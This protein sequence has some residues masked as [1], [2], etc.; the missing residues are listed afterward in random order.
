VVVAGSYEKYVPD[1]VPRK[2]IL[3]PREVMY[4]EDWPIGFGMGRLRHEFSSGNMNFHGVGA[5]AAD[6]RK[7]EGLVS[8]NDLVWLHGLRI[9]N[10]FKRW[11]WPNSILDIDDIPSEF[12][13]S[14]ASQATGL[15]ARLKAMR[16]IVLWKRHEARIMERFDSVGVCSHQDKNHF[17]NPNRVFVLP[18]GFD[19]PEST[20]VHAPSTPP[21]I[22]FIGTLEY[23]PNLNGLRWFIRE[24]WPSIR[25]K[26]PGAALR[27]MGKHSESSEFTT[28]PGIEGL[29]W[30]ADSDAEMATWA[31]TVVPIFEGGGTRVKISNAFSRKCPVVSTSL[32][33][34]GY[35]VQ[36]DRELLLA[37][38]PTDFAA[39]CLRVMENPSLGDRIAETAWE[40]F[41]KKW[42][43]EANLPTLQNLLKSTLARSGAPKNLIF[44][45]GQPLDALASVP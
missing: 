19:V 18:N 16:H 37:D 4:F 42:T 10:G 31:C 35:D 26:L 41:L 23:S 5:S 8:Q 39:A 25:H 21:R 24:V 13:K 27:I 30:V 9:A 38:T 17:N 20:P 36:S 2:G 40:A 29:G 1:A 7:V 44:K 22:G 6:C 12:Y 11:R 34:H 14:V 32:G 33:A 43:W 45:N 3:K 15:K 28:T